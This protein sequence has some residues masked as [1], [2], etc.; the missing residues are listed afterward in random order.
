[1]KKKTAM[2][3]VVVAIILIAIAG[4]IGTGVIPMPSASTVPIASS[5]SGASGGAVGGV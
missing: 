3:I 4:L 1:M 5:P 2:I